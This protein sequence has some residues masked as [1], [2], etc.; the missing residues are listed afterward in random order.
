MKSEQATYLT[1]ARQFPRDRETRESHS[2]S[3]SATH[4]TQCGYTQCGGIHRAARV[5]HPPTGDKACDCL[6]LMLAWHR[7]HEHVPRHVHIPVCIMYRAQLSHAGSSSVA[8]SRV[9]NLRNAETSVMSGRMRSA[10]RTCV[11]SYV[12]R[13]GGRGGR[14]S[15]DLRQGHHGGLLLTRTGAGDAAICVA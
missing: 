6:A 15:S 14:K 4:G 11:F 7:V 8:L 13:H 1:V 9:E 5:T 3:S 12:A 2:R 10:T